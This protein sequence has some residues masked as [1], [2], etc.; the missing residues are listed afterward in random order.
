MKQDDNF[1]QYAR[2]KLFTFQDAKDAYETKRESIKKELEILYVQKKIQSKITGSAIREIEMNFFKQ[3]EDQSFN[4]MSNILSESNI[5]FNEDYLEKNA[6][7]SCSERN[8]ENKRTNQ[9]KSSKKKDPILKYMDLE[10]E[11][12]GEDEF[13]DIEEY[14][15]LEDI[16]DLDCLESD[17]KAARVF[18]NE[19]AKEDQI[20]LQKLK[21]RF[22]THKKVLKLEKNISTHEYLSSDDLLSDIEEID[23]DFVETS[24]RP[25][26]VFEKNVVFAKEGKFSALNNDGMFNND[27]DILEKL[28]KKKESKGF[29]FKKA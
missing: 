23:L 25:I 7:S 19:Q 16:L 1:I 29:S 21:K 12:S 11:C 9:E 24:E 18:Y 27:V 6:E 8:T 28:N 3:E 10:A 14:E 15:D 4:D 13:D 22:S 5:V 20:E 26:E 2:N 17:G